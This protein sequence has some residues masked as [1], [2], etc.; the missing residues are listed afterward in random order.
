MELVMMQL[1]R[2]AWLLA[3]T[4]ITPPAACSMAAKGVGGGMDGLRS[5]SV[6]RLHAQPYM[7]Y[8]IGWGEAHDGA[9]CSKVGLDQG[10][11]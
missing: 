6:A 9:R 11:R 2:C 4:Y 3:S 10:A 7:R 5:A 1:V 8:L